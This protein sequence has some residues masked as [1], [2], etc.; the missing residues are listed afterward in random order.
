MLQPYPGRVGN[1]APDLHVLQ[2]DH[3]SPDD[4]DVVEDKVVRHPDQHER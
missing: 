4:G 2:G 1:R 3:E